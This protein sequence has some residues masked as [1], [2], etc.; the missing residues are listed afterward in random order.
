MAVAKSAQTPSRST[1]ET[2]ETNTTKRTERAK[3]AK[4]K[5]GKERLDKLLV[6]RGLCESRSRA[7]ALI[8][9]GRVIVG[10]HAESKPGTAVAVD[11]PLRVKG[12]EHSFASRGGL[13]LQG[14][15]DSFSQ[16]G[17][18]GEPGLG[19]EGRIAMDVGASTGG[20]T[21]CLLQAGVVRVYAVDVGYGQLAWRLA[22]DPR[23]INIERQNI[24]TMARETIPEPI[25]LVVI[26]CSF[27]SLTKVLPS[28]PPFLAERA[29]I[30]ALIKPQ[31]EVGR[32]GIGKGGI[33]RN[34]A[35]RRWA[36]ETVEGAARELGLHVKRVCNSPITGQKG[37]HELLIWL[38]WDAS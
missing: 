26:D 38:S 34:P 2:G 19:V 29:D 21:D 7:Q 31:F 18:E 32:E 5:P 14:A 1:A 11:A 10:D 37:N 28:L 36:Q 3:K 15:L 27:I 20:F 9:A 24:R 16:V 35:A 22:Q 6:A 12:D 25:D 17:R 33:V 8:I 23:V 4:K 13:K 30:V